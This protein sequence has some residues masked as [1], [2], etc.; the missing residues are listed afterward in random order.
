[1]GEQGILPSSP[2][3]QTVLRTLSQSPA[4]PVGLSSETMSGK[5]L[6][7]NQPQGFY[8]VIHVLIT[9][10]KQIFAK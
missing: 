1:V 8:L 2:N 5:R 7:G 10:Q 9:I 3:C 6:V 4:L